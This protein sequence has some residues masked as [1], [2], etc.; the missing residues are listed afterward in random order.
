MTVLILF[1]PAKVVYGHSPRS[2][3]RRPDISRSRIDLPIGPLRPDAQA[4][5]AAEFRTAVYARQRDQRHWREE[6]YYSFRHGDR[7]CPDPERFWKDFRHNP[8]C[9]RSRSNAP[10]RKPR[11]TRWTTQPSNSW[12]CSSHSSRVGSLSPGA[13]RSDDQRQRHARGVE[14]RRAAL[15]A[16]PHYCGLASCSRLKF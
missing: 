13:E 5:P 2:A 14:D 3:I 6:V 12:H 8:R 1:G 11:G 9:S 15:A 7:W 16:R 4:A 10:S